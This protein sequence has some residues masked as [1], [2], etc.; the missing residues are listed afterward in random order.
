MSLPW[1]SASVKDLASR[2]Q[3]LTR[4]DVQSCIHQL[5]PRYRTLYNRISLRKTCNALA[6]HVQQRALSLFHAGA[7][8]LGDVYLAHFPFLKFDS[9]SDKDV[10]H[11]I[12]THEFGAL[13]I[14]RLSQEIPSQSVKLRSARLNQ[15][16]NALADIINVRAEREREWPMPVSKEVVFE[17]LN[18]YMKGTMWSEPSVCAVCS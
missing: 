7:S 16:Q 9:L 4:T 18:G 13:V 3:K 5:A 1:I 14:E 12:L 10:I 2:L 17:C 15:K 8:V 6:N 11:Q